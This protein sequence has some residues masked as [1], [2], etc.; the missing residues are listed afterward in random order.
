MS[1]VAALG[2]IA[3]A[4]AILGLVGVIATSVTAEVILAILG[5]CLL[6]YA[7]GKLRL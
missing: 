2:V 3:I 5:I 1:I 4:L 7:S 6:A